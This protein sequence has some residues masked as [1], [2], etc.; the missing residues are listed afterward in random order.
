ML[1]NVSMHDYRHVFKSHFHF[2]IYIYVYISL[3]AKVVDYN[4]LI[5]IFLYYYFCQ[6]YLLPK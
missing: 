1:K 5:N 6:D 2:H 3:Y 4:L